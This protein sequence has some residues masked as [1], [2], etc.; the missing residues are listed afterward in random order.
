MSHETTSPPPPSRPNH[1]G[2]ATHPVHKTLASAA[3][4]ANLL[5]TGTVLAFQALTPSFSNNGVCRTSNKYLTASLVMFCAVICVLSSFTDSFLDSDGNLY[6]GIATFNGLHIF[7]IHHLKDNICS[8]SLDLWRFRIRLMDYVHA[9]VS[10]LVFLVFAFCDSDLQKCYFP[11][12]GK[13][14]DAL[15][16]NL[17]LAAGI[18]SSFL[19]MIFPTTRRGIGYSDALC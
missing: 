8:S 6:Y 10:L 17:P 13:D 4:L 2:F 7:N 3:N 18:F 9:V 12:G 16:M 11:L 19:F 15:V 1:F 14:L 5:P